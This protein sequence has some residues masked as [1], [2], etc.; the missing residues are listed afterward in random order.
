MTH[1]SSNAQRGFSLTEV[2]VAVAVFA[3]IFVAALMVYDRANRIFKTGVDSSDVQQTTRAAFERMVADIRMAGFDFD[4]DGYPTGAKKYQQPDEQLEFIHPHALTMRTNLNYETA[5]AA[6]NGREE[7]YEPGKTTTATDD[8]FFP[9]VTT[10]NN[11]IVTYALKS[12]SGPNDDSITFYADVAKPRDTYPD[13]GGSNET[14]VTIPDVDLCQDNAGV[15]TGCMNPPYT[16][17]RITLKDDGTPD[18]PVPIA[19]NIRSV[20]YTYFADALTSVAI[21]PNGGGGQFIVTGG[22]TTPA[23]ITARELRGGVRSVRINLVGMSPG[24]DRDYVE[25]L[26]TALPTAQQVAAARNRRQ[27]SLQSTVIPRNLGKRGV[28]EIDVRVPGAPLITNVCTEGCGAPRVEW[29]APPVGYVDSYLVLWDTS[30]S[31]SF[32]SPTTDA[33]RN[34]FAYVEG[35][36]PAQEYWFKVVAK[37]DF[38]SEFSAMYPATGVGTGI[39]PLNRT[40]PMPPQIVS[41]TGNATAGQP[42][43]VANDI[44]VTFRAP[45]QNVGGPTGP[46]NSCGNPAANPMPKEA[47][48]YKVFRST[49]A[50]AAGT[51]IWSG[52]VAVAPATGP[53]VLNAGTGL[54][55]FTDAAPKLACQL[56]YYTVSAEERCADDPAFNIP[57]GVALASSALS[58]EMGGQASGAVAPKAPADVHATVASTC[59]TNPCSISLEW[60]ESN[61]DAND[62]PILVAQYTVRRITYNAGIMVAGSE[63]TFPVTDPTPGDGAKVTFTDTTAPQPAVGVIY[64]YSVSAT[65]CAGTPITS[66]YST[67]DA[68]FPCA[69]LSVVTPPGMIDGDG[70]SGNPWLIGDNDAEIVVTSNTDLVTAMATVREVGSGTTTTLPSGMTANPR[71]AAWSFAMAG[72]SGVFEITMQFTDVLGC[73]STVIRYVQESP[74]SCCLTPYKDASG[75]IFDASVITHTA[76]STDVVLTLKNQCD[77]ALRID[78]LRLVWNVTQQNDLERVTYPGGIND[79]LGGGIS[80]GTAILNPG[81]VGASRTIP[82]N[83]TYRIVL[84]FDR[85]NRTSIAN[86][87]NYCARYRRGTNITNEDCRVVQTPG[88]T[89]P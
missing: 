5:A 20:S 53:A 8:D 29:D 7:A 27:Y 4:R 85:A 83:G 13:V 24:I 40:K 81:T 34:R 59:S 39:R 65:Q 79:F 9:V 69:I 50:G 10:A 48:R 32:N 23:A 70:S 64:H 87:L 60:N 74:T 62:K 15:L 58:N 28:Q 11:E 80:S 88:T 6:D 18:T 46:L 31:G 67:P 76:G 38:G 44:I 61:L 57:S 63:V 68:K 25:P 84:R 71:Q 72:S 42:A 1:R 73:G 19:N 12:D 47:L 82:A 45:N 56:Y 17:Y 51:E 54:V 21:T 77:Q 78:T 26:E 3:L 49:T 16:L 52:Q 36:D 41:V 66:A 35:L 86:I 43:A 14:L 89:C 22:T 75:T 37:N 2:L 55:T 30:P 33:G